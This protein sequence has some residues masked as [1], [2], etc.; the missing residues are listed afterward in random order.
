[1]AQQRVDFAA[2]KSKLE[3]Y[4]SISTKTPNSLIAVPDWALLV[5]LAIYVVTGGLTVLSYTHT[6]SPRDR[7]KAADSFMI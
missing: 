4:R 7:E 5:A 6:G 3:N 1:M 2:F